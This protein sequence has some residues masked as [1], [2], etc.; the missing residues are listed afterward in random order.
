MYDGRNGVVHDRV[1]K[2][3]VLGNGAIDIERAALQTNGIVF[4]ELAKAI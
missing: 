1:T 2:K 3:L 4:L